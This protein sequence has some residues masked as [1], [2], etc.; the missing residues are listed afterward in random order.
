MLSNIAKIESNR[1]TLFLNVTKVFPTN[2][3][4]SVQIHFAKKNGR[5]FAQSKK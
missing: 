3:S 2:S 1:V 4:A 5:K